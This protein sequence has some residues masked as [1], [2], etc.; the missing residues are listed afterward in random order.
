MNAI[1]LSF[2]EFALIGEGI[3]SIWCV[4]ELALDM[5]FTGPAKA[6]R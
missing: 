6:E 3:R 4:C 5:T 2:P 1:A